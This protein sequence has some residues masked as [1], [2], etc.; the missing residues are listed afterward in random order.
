M[1]RGIGWST[2]IAVRTL[3]WG[4]RRAAEFAA[5]PNALRAS[6]PGGF[7]LRYTQLSAAQRNP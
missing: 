4:T 6:V 1:G 2:I 5:A 7:E 3:R